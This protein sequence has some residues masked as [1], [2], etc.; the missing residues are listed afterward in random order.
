V[1][2]DQT[3]P[4]RGRRPG[5][6]DTRG[7]ILDAA[8]SLF[9]ERG[10]ERTSIRAIA[11]RAGVDSALVHHYFGSKESVFL[12]AVELPFEPEAVLPRLLDGDRDS[13]GERFARFVA[14]LLEDDVARAR[15]LAIIR[16]AASEPAAASILRGLVERRLRDP[17]AQALGTADAELRASLVGSQVVG[18]VMARHVV[19]VEPLA[20]L[21]PPQLASLLA[22]TLQRYLAEPLEPRE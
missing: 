9:A 15:M 3:G 17:I 2:Q 5:R 21:T 19:G 22:P 8:R 7:E 1:R 18:L 13:I 14:A 10:F 4:R 16:A 20:S 6:A 12:A 11:R